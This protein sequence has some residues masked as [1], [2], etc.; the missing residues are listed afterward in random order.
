MRKSTIVILLAI[1]TL[2][3]V[4]QT[5]NACSDWPHGL[6]YICF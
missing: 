2:I 6:R 1:A 5:A 4:S 3:V